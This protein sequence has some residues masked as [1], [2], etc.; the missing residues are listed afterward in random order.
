MPD[1][2]PQQDNLN[3]IRSLQ[4]IFAAQRVPASGSIN[5]TNRCNLNCV[6]CYLGDSNSNLR[7]SKEELTTGQ[8]LNVIDQVTEA[9]CLY[10]L[11][12]GGEILLRSDFE[13][14]YRKAVTSGLLVTVF[15]NGT[16]LNDETYGIFTDLPP[17]AIEIS[18]Y[19]ASPETYESITGVKGSFQ[20][21]LDGIQGLHDHQVRFNL[22]TM[23]L[24]QNHHE[25]DNIE[26]IAQ[27][28]G[29]EFRMDPAVSA[30][31]DG[32]QQPMNCRVDPA[33]A[34][35][36]EFSTP[37]KASRWLQYYSQRKKSPATEYLYNCGAGLTNFH[38]EP[39]GTLSPCTMLSSPSFS[40]TKGSFTEGWNNELIKLRNIKTA[41]N[42]SCNA[43][44][45]SILCSGCPATFALESGSSE[46]CSQYLCEIARHRQKAINSHLQVENSTLK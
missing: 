41:G 40:L 30:C 27:E 35:Q 9:G 29:V 37:E 22:K 26:K 8:W 25:T 24:T 7:S 3:N 44:D 20:K 43:C 32:N 2:F 33:A 17:Q 6:H 19:G 5:L 42:Y 16:L 11:L 18:L 38:I 31:L 14:I 46:T 1:Q 12:S 28:F 23:I 13:A 21:C 34:V 10:L 39:D 15:T 36:A 4:R 45:I